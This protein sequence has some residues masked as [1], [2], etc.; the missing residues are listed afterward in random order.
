MT[1]AG[2]SAFK[3]CMRDVALALLGEP[4]TE[5]TRDE[6]RFGSGRGSL[7][8]D[9]RKGVWCDAGN[10]D[11]GGGVIA[12]VMH[13][14]NVEK[15]EALQWLTDNGYLEK[16]TRQP[17]TKGQIVQTYDYVSEDG[18]LLFQ[19]CRMD[20][21]DFRQHKP[22]AGGKWSWSTKGERRVLYRLPAV[23]QAV[24][25]GQPVYIVEGEKS[26]QRLA[27]LGLVATCSP[28][29][30]G[31]WKPD[32][33]TSLRGA[34]VLILPDNDAPGRDHA[35]RVA[36]ALHGT[37]QRVRLVNLPDLPPKGDVWDWLEA[38]HSMQELLALV[39]AAESYDPAAV[40]PSEILSPD[41]LDMCLRDDRGQPIPN[42]ANVLLALRAD[43]AYSGLFAYNQMVCLPYLMQ[44]FGPQAEPFSPRPVTD[45][46][47]THVQ[48]RL[49]IAGLRRVSKEIMHQGVNCVAAERAYHP[50]RD[51]L[52]GLQWDGIPRLDTWLTDYLGADLTQ[53][54]QGIGRMFMIAMVARIFKPGCKADYMMVLEGLQGAR[55]STACAILGGD[56]YS[57]GMPDLKTGK[58]VQMH[59]RGKWL[60]EIAELSALG[61]AEN[62][63]LKHF[64]TR[65][66]ERFRPPFGRCEVIEQRQCLFVGTTNKA[67]YLS[68][69]TGGRRY[70]P[71][72]TGEI[73]IKELA[74]DRDQ[75]FAE[76]VRAFGHGEQ[77]WP[78]SD[79][80]KTFINPEQEARFEVDE[81]EGLIAAYLSSRQRVTIL[82][83]AYDAL[84]FENKKVG[85][86]EQRR[87][88]KIM[89]RLGWKRG[90]RG[91]GGVRF[92]E[93]S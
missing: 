68:D 15:P 93:K 21:K 52:K 26:A 14:K 3:A 73:S 74:A 78:D 40:E 69:E 88:A 63:M 51:Y 77:W 5:S 38:G 4:T 79:F 53:Y 89:E 19:V 87:I 82:N 57:D 75:L 25:S 41:W 23:L 59:L 71:V 45:E 80:E 12:L 13:V 32:Y 50:V 39:D 72:K 56:W 58:D 43:P 8:V 47:V 22:V 33:A 65:T 35:N 86:S 60:L 37:A 85:T 11:L 84:F 17:R 76:A 92:W 81:W 90:L 18:E 6:L 36:K 31:K 54:N 9:L 48:E 20:P 55:K 67:V 16:Q 28:G 2:K 46:D 29:G 24:Q 49:Q 1:A 91:T 30:A 34:D 64:I 83:V 7:A 61:K 66:T 62:E 42:V 70:W 44:P 27:E 10:P